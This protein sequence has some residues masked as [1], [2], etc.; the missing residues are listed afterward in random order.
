[1]DDPIE[2]ALRKKKDSSMRVAIQ[3]VKDG[4]AQAAISAGNTGA[5][6]AIARY[7]VHPSPYTNVINL[8]R[9]AFEDLRVAP[10]PEARVFK[11]IAHSVCDQL[12]DRTRLVL[13]TSAS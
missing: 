7:L 1:M 4:A 3:Q 13:W 6:M 9:W 10:Y 11:S 8:Q 5:L 12:P 2:I